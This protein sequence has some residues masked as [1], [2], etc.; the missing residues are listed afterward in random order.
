MCHGLNLAGVCLKSL[1]EQRLTIACSSYVANGATCRNVGVEVGHD[2]LGSAQNVTVV[3]AVPG[4]QQLAVLA[5]KRR[6][7]GGGASV[8]TNE[9]TAGVVL[10]VTLGH[11]LLGMALME[12]L[13]LCIVCKERLQTRYL[14]T[15]S[16]AEVINC[17]DELR[18]RGELVGLVRHS[19]ARSHKQVS[20]LGHN[21]VLLIKLERDVETAAQL[22][23]ILQRA[24]KECHVA[25][26]G[27]TT[28]KARN[29]LRYHSLEDGSRNVLGARTFV[30]QRLHIGLS[31]HA[32]AA[33]DGINSGCV[34]GK[35]V[36]ATCIGVKQR[37]HLIDKST[38]AACA[39]TIHA[40]LNAVIKV[41]NLCVLAAQLN[42]N[43]GS[44]NKGL[45]RALASD[46]LL[47]KLQA[48]PLAEQKTTRAC[49]GAGHLRVRQKRRRTHKEVTRTGAHVGVVT[50]ILGVDN[51]V[52]IVE[53]CK[54][55]RRGAYVDTKMKLAGCRLRIPQRALRRCGHRRLRCTCLLIHVLV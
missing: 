33:S 15:L 52:V 27:A 46:N 24:T 29:G 5:H 4:V 17:F 9:H 18:E 11:N 37:C 16:V 2:D 8:D 38:R 19:C 55:H 21:A 6:L 7:H 31:K 36:Q 13:K 53:H 54:L 34:L 47:Y 50:L 40:L 25:A 32:A 48:K 41:D 42:S 10:Q 35:L 45:Y 39:G 28:R 43:V 49:N 14:R 26:D 22:R 20:V 44:R 30:E 12:L 51:L 1:D 3:A 23:E